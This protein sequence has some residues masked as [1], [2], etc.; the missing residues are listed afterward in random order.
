[1]PMDAEGGQ[2][3]DAITTAVHAS[4]W[5][6]TV[7]NS[8]RMM[9]PSGTLEHAGPDAMLQTR[10]IMSQRPL[11][12]VRGELPRLNFTCRQWIAVEVCRV[13]S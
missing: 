4:D 10:I 2:S 6:T 7:S 11:A 9:A 5:M 8:V 13:L 1:M 12:T 3:P